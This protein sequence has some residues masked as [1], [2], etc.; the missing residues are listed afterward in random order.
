MRRASLRLSLFVCAGCL[1]SALGQDYVPGGLEAVELER[2]VADR[3]VC[4]TQGQPALGNWEPYASVLGKSVFLV[5]SNTFSESEE[6]PP[7]QRYVVL[8]QPVDGSEPVLGEAFFADDGTPYRGKIN[9]YRQNGNPGRVA[10]DK[11]PGA[12]NF[13]VGGETSA[14]E[15]PEF[16]S[17]DRWDTGVIRNGRYATVQTYE[18]DLK[19]LAQKPLCKAFDAANGRLTEGNPGTQEITR[20]GGDLAALDNGNFV[21]LVEDRSKLHDPSAS[22]AA[23]AVIVAPDGSIVK[24]SFVVAPT[25]IWSNLAAYKGGFCVR[26]G[27]VLKFFD[28]DGNLLGEADQADP[29]LVDPLGN[30]IAFDRGR[31]DG[32]RIASHINSPYVFLA[33]KSGADVRIAVWDSRDFSYVA[34][35]NVNE[36]TEGNGGT[37]NDDFR[38]PF[39]RVNL[40]VDALNR[41]VVAYEA[42]LPDLQAQTVVRV[43]AFDEETLEF[44]Y[45]TPSFFPFVNFDD[46]AV[47]PPTATKIR[48][49]RPTVAMT[50]REILIAAKGEINSE[51]DPTLGA[52]TPTETNFYT[53]FAHP[54]P[55]DDPTPPIGVVR[56][57]FR[58]GDVND[59]GK[60]DI[61]DGIFHLSHLFLG[62][63][64]WNC[65][66]GADIN[67]DGKQDI[68]DP[69]YLLTHLFL[70][71]PEPPA[72]YPDCGEDPGGA[73][74]PESSCNQ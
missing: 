36:L 24:D 64:R 47:V 39:D 31:G 58:R 56:T 70:G 74:C 73:E 34:Q 29:N 22:K 44:S 32:T 23:V 49:F 21:V 5:E 18:L 55:K 53:V 4:D 68:S 66:E 71:G 3:V 15:F 59:D 10:G 57:K 63:E 52:D 69:V 46:G 60:H 45:L 13:I 40:A 33:G 61:S 9:S 72:P 26:A 50:T 51:N 16:R 43:L 54:D 1:G 17:D 20:F 7:T 14:D 25:E 41:V 19:T 48:T 30:P 27:G 38:V 8:F 67:G 6:V 65:D 12:V 35:A 2:I 28:N 42:T 11:R 37:D 62:G